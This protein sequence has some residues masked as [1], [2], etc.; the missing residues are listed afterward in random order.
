VLVGSLCPLFSRCLDSRP[1]PSVDRSRP[2]VSS[3][4]FCPREAG[5]ANC[6]RRPRCYGVAGPVPPPAPRCAATC[7]QP[8]AP[9]ATLHEG[10][11]ARR[12]C[13]DPPDSPRNDMTRPRH[14][15]DL[16]TCP[17]RI[18]RRPG[19]LCATL[20]QACGVLSEERTRPSSIRRIDVDP[21]VLA[22]ED[23]NRALPLERAFEN[24]NPD[25]QELR[26]QSLCHAR[27]GGRHGRAL[28]TAFPYRDAVS[29][30]APGAA[31]GLTSVQLLDLC[32]SVF[33][34][35]E[36]AIRLARDDQLREA[37][38]GLYKSNRNDRANPCSQQQVRLYL[39]PV[40]RVRPSARRCAAGCLTCP[41]HRSLRRA[42]TG[43]DLSD[44]PRASRG[45]AR[46]GPCSTVPFVSTSIELLLV[47]VLVTSNSSRFECNDLCCRTRLD[48]NEWQQAQSGR[49]EP[50]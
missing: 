16:H 29:A 13:L 28:H 20:H 8:P 24:R 2:G 5:S 41:P 40:R 22:N 46:V 39:P 26:P 47:G 34:A 19:R 48:S 18:K 15:P 44:C 31:H 17:A 7:Q 27:L 3:R 33:K 10:P 30:V 45:P 9:P 42:R 37:V 49:R 32:P 25:R 12:T 50:R 38:M 35:R 14:A 21:D 4:V 23:A 1:A 43:P 11:V 36:D 6:K